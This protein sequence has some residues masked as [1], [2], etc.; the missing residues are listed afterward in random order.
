MARNIVM[1]SDGTGNK[2]GSGSD[3]NVFKIYE[4]V[5]INDIPDTERQQIVFYDNGVGTSK[6][7]L[8]KALGGGLGLGFRQNVRDL[9]EFLG[10]NYVAGDHV[11]LF[12]FSRGAATVRAF[13]GMLQYCGLVVKRAG[14]P[15]NDL[16]EKDFQSQINAA[17]D[18]YV[19][20]GPMKATTFPYGTRVT[21]EFVGIWDTV[22]A[23]GVPQLGKIDDLL[24]LVR[25][26]KFFDYEPATCV[27][28]VFHAM[29]VDDER[30]T[31]WPL[32]WNEK[33]FNG[34]GVIEQVWFAGMHANVGGGYPRD[35]LAN[36]T[37]AWMMQKLEDNCRSLQET[38]RTAGLALL[39]HAREA[40]YAN[41]N[42]H[43][44]LYDSRGGLSKFYRYQPRPIDVLCSEAHTPVRIH[45]SVLDRLEKR[46]AGY[47]PG[48]LPAPGTFE[49]AVTAPR[50][51]RPP[52]GSSTV[53]V[54]AS[55]AADT[56]KNV[57]PTV[58]PSEDDA[59]A[60]SD[61]YAAL[62]KQ[63]DAVKN[64]RIVLYWVFLLSA[65]V[66]LVASGALWIFPPAGIVDLPAWRSASVVNW[67]LGH[68]AGG[69]EYVLPTFFDGAITALVLQCPV[70]FAALLLY[71]AGMYGLHAYLK[72]TMESIEEQARLLMLAGLKRRT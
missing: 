39:P 43:G 37:L 15:L 44:K 47:T 54:A 58:G 50:A 7:S 3:T 40:A 35:E 65:V 71:A 10:R 18:H 67:I 45:Q 41:A 52:S 12:G 57:A 29:A 53:P 46:S 62:R 64:R 34:G 2:G 8:K 1:C 31:F 55:A 19:N 30:R 14:D 27:K 32:V 61:R 28:N 33:D 56:P 26:H 70:G 66:L 38:D 13:A 36:V 17:R 68:I 49:V 48:N 25:R 5:K 42:P 9:Y 6:F 21:V 24:N 69:L 22:A 11:Y 63:L 4:A 51:V 72:I 20:R 59:A 16:N 60:A 23:L